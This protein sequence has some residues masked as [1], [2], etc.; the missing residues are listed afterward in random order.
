MTDQVVWKQKCS[1]HHHHTQT[2][3]NT[4]TSRVHTQDPHTWVHQ[5]EQ[6]SCR[7]NMEEECE[8]ELALRP[9]L[10]LLLLLLKLSAS[11]ILS[12]V[13]SVCQLSPHRPSMTYAL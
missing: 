11:L 3:T 2:H 8:A 5:L 1:D 13:A 9:L 4:H 12:T 10:L 6:A 7:G